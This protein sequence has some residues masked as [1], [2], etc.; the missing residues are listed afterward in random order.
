VKVSNLAKRTTNYCRGISEIFG[1]KILQVVGRGNSRNPTQ[2]SPRGISWIDKFH[3][4]YTLGEEVMPSMHKGMEVKFAVR[5]LDKK[6]VVVKIRDKQQS[7][8]YKGE[9]AAWRS[10]TDLMLNM[11]QN[12]SIAQLYEV[13]E[14]HKAY[15]VIMEKCSG[16]DLFEATHHW[17][18][19]PVAVVKEVIRQIL[20]ALEE[21]HANG[22]I[23]KDVKLENIMVSPLA[24][25]ARAN[26]LVNDAD[27]SPVSAS[28]FSA[29]RPLMV[30]LIDFDTVV[31]WSPRTP[32]P[33]DVL[34]T[35]QY[36]AQEAYEGNYSPASDIFAVGVIAYRLLTGRFPFRKSIFNDEQ[37]ENYVGSP[38]M[39]EIQSKLRASKI[40]WNFPVFHTDPQAWRFVQA[41]LATSELER[42]SA[43]EALL[44]PWLIGMESHMPSPEF[45]AHEQPTALPMQATLPNCV[46]DNADDDNVI[47]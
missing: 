32:R 47:G 6:E 11:P 34:G 4:A 27:G 29:G 9:E 19:P 26:N 13:L 20:A 22:V 41:L 5:N 21:L 24:A 16:Q 17:G 43:N 10:S 1:S 35:D 3:D 8:C 39:K 31:P 14:D 45:S 7:F 2:E 28:G 18:I 44:H 36:I 23:H 33:K 30:K 12:G 42:P 38:K 15:Y 40:E 25:S 46:E 37:G